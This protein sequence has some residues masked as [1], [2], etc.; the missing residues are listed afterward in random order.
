[1][2]TIQ[3]IHFLN[4]FACKRSLFRLGI[5]TSIPL[6]IEMR[7][8]DHKR[9]SNPS[10]DFLLKIDCNRQTETGTERVPF[11][12]LW[13]GTYKT[14]SYNPWDKELTWPHSLVYHIGGHSPPQLLSCSGFVSLQAESRRCLPVPPMHN[15]PRTCLPPHGEVQG[16]HSPEISAKSSISFELQNSYA[17]PC[18]L[19]THYRDVKGDHWPKINSKFSIS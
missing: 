12:P 16:D 11:L 19:I 2:K 7:E 4:P 13:Y 5:H 17:F 14:T 3:F 6:W 8:S 1:M 9:I 10:I 18:A 15:T